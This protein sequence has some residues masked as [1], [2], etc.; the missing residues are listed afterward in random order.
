ME[1]GW[2]DTHPLDKPATDNSTV[3][4]DDE[5]TV[6]NHTCLSTL[7]CQPL[8]ISKSADLNTTNN[9][10]NNS[11][12]KSEGEDEYRERTEDLPTIGSSYEE[13]NVLSN[14]IACNSDS[15]SN[16]ELS[17]SDCPQTHS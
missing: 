8:S 12:L 10:D 11:S 14:L 6:Y 17:S 9:M 3:L 13:E 1:A 2:D 16:S 5:Y 7:V 15:D 4:R